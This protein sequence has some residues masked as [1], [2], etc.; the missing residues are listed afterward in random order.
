MHAVIPTPPTFVAGVGRH[1]IFRTRGHAHGPRLPGYAI[2]ALGRWR[3]AL[4]LG[5]ILRV[6]RILVMASFVP[7]CGPSITLVGWPQL[8]EPGSSKLV[9]DRASPSQPQL[10]EST[11]Y[12]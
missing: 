4:A 1:V 11:L 3:T 8:A 9:D 7:D 5:S 2:Y 10:P 12:R 6:R